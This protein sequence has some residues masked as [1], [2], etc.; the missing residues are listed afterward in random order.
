LFYI[1]RLHLSTYHN[2]PY[3][4]KYQ[5]DYFVTTGHIRL[6]SYHPVLFYSF[7]QQAHE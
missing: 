4:E 6:N 1:Y 5:V 7:M 2:T 3:Y